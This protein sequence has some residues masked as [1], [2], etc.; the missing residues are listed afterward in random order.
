M[1]HNSVIRILLQVP[2]LT[3]KFILQYYSTNEFMHMHANACTKIKF[4]LIIMQLKG[5]GKQGQK[6]A[7]IFS[8]KKIAPTH[9]R[10]YFAHNIII[11]ILSPTCVLTG[12]RKFSSRIKWRDVLSR[13]LECAFL[14]FLTGGLQLSAPIKFRI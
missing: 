10:N 5:S 11:I 6:D 7:F 2:I 4:Q 13:N 9:A 14:P 1:I 12:T 8:R 3:R